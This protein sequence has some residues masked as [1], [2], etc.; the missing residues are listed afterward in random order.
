MRCTDV[1]RGG[2]TRLVASW[3]E[4]CGGT[5]DSGEAGCPSSIH[6]AGRYADS[7]NALGIGD[8]HSCRLYVRSGDVSSAA[9]LLVRFRFLLSRGSSSR[10]R[11][12]WATA[13]GGMATDAACWQHQTLSRRCS[14]ARWRL[15]MTVRWDGGETTR[16][17]WQAW[18]LRRRRRGGRLRASGGGVCHYLRAWR[19]AAA[20]PAQHHVSLCRG[21]LTSALARH[22]GWCRFSS[23]DARCARAGRY[24]AFGTGGAGRER[25]LLVSRGWRIALAA[26]NAGGMLAQ[27]M[28][29][30]ACL[31]S[32]LPYPPAFYTDTLRAAAC[33]LPLS[34]P[35]SLQLHCTFHDDLPSPTFTWRRRGAFATDGGR[36]GIGR[37]RQ[38]RTNGTTC[39][40]SFA[41]LPR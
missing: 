12:L 8:K 30:L 28:L 5:A 4:W 37:Q 34:L 40:G 22:H 39:R 1:R 25:S 11:F 31:T 18:A 14:P 17:C 29:L 6:T 16:L 38:E 32:P 3:A 21:T 10:K 23:D 24:N 33:H 15:N 7:G 26:E 36:D 2:A 13:T 19:W 35:S 27:R 9:G 20:Y 41:P